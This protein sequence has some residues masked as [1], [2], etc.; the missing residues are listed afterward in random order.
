M[1]VHHKLIFVCISTIFVMLGC[2]SNRPTVIVI[3]S[4]S[5]P[6]SVDAVVDVTSAPNVPLATLSVSTAIPT[7]AT[8]PGQHIV[9]GGDTLSQIASDNNVS[10]QYLIS[11]NSIPNPDL[12]EVG[13]IIYLPDAPSTSTLNFQIVPDSRLVRSRSASAFDL[14]SFIASQPGII[15]NITDTVTTRLADGSALDEILGSASIIERVSLEYSIDPRIFLVFLEY[16][17]NWLSQI[18]VAED[19]QSFP[20]ISA[21]QSSGFD[22]DGLYQQLSWLGNELNRGYYNAKYRGANILEFEDGTRQF[23]NDSLNAATISLQYTLALNNT[24]SQWLFDVSEQGFSSVYQQYFGDPFVD[25]IE[26]TP[27]NLTQPILNLPFK[28]GDVWRFTGGFHGGWGS[29]SA[30]AALDF[31][32]PDDRKDGDAFCYT[33]AYPITAVSD[34]KIVRSSRGVIV[35]D[36]DGD[37]DESTGWTI[38]YLHISADASVAVGQDV[39]AGDTIGYASCHGGFSTA[40]HLHI[41][42]RYNGEWIPADCANCSTSIVTPPFV[43]GD[44]LAIGLRNQQ[45]QGYM[46]NVADNR[47]VVAEQGRNVKINEISW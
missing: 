30:W 5:P 24:S 6:S 37:N 14:N 44:W 38:L 41:A 46:E 43:M 23:Y 10:L 16:R 29:G 19:L 32:P 25:E 15:R 28:Q 34:G 21:V 45:Y 35:L 12:L 40:T 42:R 11:I 47:R 13:Q 20:L 22:R 17:A 26:I 7:V 2:A 3:T 18:N 1:R 27:L 39:S 9:Q 31:A 8:T 36:L 4:T 33:S